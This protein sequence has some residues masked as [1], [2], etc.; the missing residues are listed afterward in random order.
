LGRKQGVYTR[1]SAAIER[2]SGFFVPG[3]EGPK[4]R[5]VFG[6]VLLGFVTLNKYVY[7][8]SNH[9]SSI[10]SSSSSSWTLSI[11]EIVTLL[12]SVLVLLQGAI[13][14][15]KENYQRLIPS[16]SSSSTSTATTTT[17][18]TYQQVWH[19]S[20]SAS[21]SFSNE[22]WKDKV[23]WAATTYLT[24]TP[25]TAMLLINGRYGTV[26]FSLIQ[27]STDCIPSSIGW[28]DP[29]TATAVR[30]AWN[31]IASSASSGRVSLPLTHPAAASLLDRIDPESSN[32][33]NT[34]TTTIRT[35]LLQR[36]SKPEKDD[37][38]KSSSSSSLFWWIASDQLL[39]AFTSRDLQWLGQLAQ[40]VDPDRP[41]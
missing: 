4:V 20:I 17:T 31:T 10:S 24:I 22:I 33:K 6:I 40:Y 41:G 14:Y 37:I 29:N 5:V 34:P 8:Y 26:L 19:V 32:D 15:Q 9:I 25:A 36:I 30:A 28:N 39:P 38:A 18:T 7:L 27:P 11:S 13:E 35:I 21:S 1:P 16:S 23:E 12:F 2:G 3:L